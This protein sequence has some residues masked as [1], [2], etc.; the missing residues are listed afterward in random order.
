MVGR[1]SIRGLEEKQEVKQVL[2]ISSIAMKK[3]KN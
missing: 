3:S 2:R 1:E